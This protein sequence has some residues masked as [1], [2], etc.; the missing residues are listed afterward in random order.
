MPRKSA[1]ARLYE[2]PE[3]KLFYIRDGS[4][5]ISTGTRDRREAEAAL[6]RHIAERDRPAGPATPD[7]L[8]VADVLDVYGREHAPTV[9]APARIGYAITAINPI[10]GN[11]PVGSINGSVCRRYE[12]TRG[13]APGTVR[14]ELG[15]LQAAINYAYAEGYLTAPVKVRL[16]AKPAPR[17]RWLSRDEAAKLLRAAYRS[18]RGKHLARYILVGLY[19][20]SRSSAILGLRFMPNTEGGWV[21]TETG[22]LHRRAAGEAETKKRT[23]PVPIPRPLLAHLRRWERNGARYVVEV[24]GQRV[25]SIKT[26]WKAALAGAGIDH[27]RPHDL[28]HTCAT[29]LMQAGADKWHAAGFLGMGLDM[30]ERTYGHHHPDHMQSAVAALERKRQL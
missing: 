6:A 17:D 9:R 8:T 29:R 7:R 18:R 25:G 24:E 22:I 16:P 30:L 20:G 12:R 1:G 3:R 15:V 5:F 21:D 14:K 11:L 2:H 28:R 19:T 13:K 4:R 10:L 23:P 26:A 27:C